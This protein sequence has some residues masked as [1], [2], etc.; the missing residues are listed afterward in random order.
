MPSDVDTYVAARGSGLRPPEL[1]DSTGQSEL[2]EPAGEIEPV[3][4]P[5]SEADPDSVGEQSAFTEIPL[6]NQQRVFTSR[7][8]R[9]AALVI[10]ATMSRPVKWEPVSKCTLT[11]REQDFTFR[12]TEFQTFAW[13]VACAARNHPKLRSTLQGDE[14]IHE[15]AHLNLGIAVG[16]KSGALATAVVRDADTLDYHEFVAEAQAAIALARA[17]SD[18]AD[19]ATQLHLTYMGQYGITDATPLLVAPAIAVMFVGAAY[20][21]EGASWV[22]LSLTFDHRLI[23]GVEGARFLKSVVE[24]IES[25]NE[26]T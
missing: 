17:G 5:A 14:M 18:Q 1:Q 10:P 21:R 25:L 24:T 6:S 23:N 19:A 11:Q 12:P 26:L 15:Y 13:C 8:R 20:P 2:P 16:L 3:S 4:G 7:I 22:N 9:S